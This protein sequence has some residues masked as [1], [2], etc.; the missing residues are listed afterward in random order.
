MVLC[1]EEHRPGLRRDDGDEA[2]HEVHFGAHLGDVELVFTDERRVDRG[3]KVDNRR[4]TISLP[5]ISLAEE[6]GPDREWT[7]GGAAA[8]CRALEAAPAS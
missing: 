7:T 5:D 6:A 4:N 3:Q 1:L 8:V 2:E